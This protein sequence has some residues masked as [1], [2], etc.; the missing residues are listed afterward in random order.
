MTK[1]EIYEKATGKRLALL[2]LSLPIG[3]T[4]EAFEASGVAVGWAWVTGESEE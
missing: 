1:Y 3:S 2:P 4:V